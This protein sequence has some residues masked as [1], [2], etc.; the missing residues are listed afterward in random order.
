MSQDASILPPGI[1]SGDTVVAQMNAAIKTAQTCAFGPTDPTTQPALYNVAEGFLW[2]NT[3]PTPDELQVWDGAG[4]VTL[5]KLDGTPGAV[6]QALLDA[7]LPLAGGTLTGF[8]TLHADPDAAMKAATKQYV[9]ATSRPS[10]VRF[11]VGGNATVANK[12]AQALIERDASCIG[13]R[14]YADTAPVGASL[15]VQITRLRTSAADDTRT[16]SILT[17]ANEATTTFGTPLALLAGDR[18]RFD[19]TSVGSTT[20]G[21]ADLMCSLVMNPP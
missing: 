9:D 2:W 4:W 1:F 17:T 16:L 3:S 15:T 10:A 11:H 8:L 12:L 18:L 19:V 14:A 7:K 6:S 21:G 13:M 5:L 20:P